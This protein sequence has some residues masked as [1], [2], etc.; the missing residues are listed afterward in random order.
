MKTIAIGDTHGQ[1]DWEKVLKQNPDFDKFIFIG[2]YFDSFNIPAIDQ[3]DNFLQILNFQKQNP[4]KVVL[5][6]GNHDFHYLPGIKDK[7]SGFQT[8]FYYQIQEMLNFAKPYL[9]MCFK[10]DNILFTHAGIT[11][12]WLNEQKQF[13]ESDDVEEIINQIYTSKPNNFQFTIGPNLSQYGDDKCQTPIW[14]RPKSLLRDKIDNFIQVV[15]HT[16]HDNLRIEDD[17]Y[18]IDTLQTSK[19]YLIIEDGNFKIGEIL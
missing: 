12:T 6:I 4:D 18:F 14:V 3:L 17:V 8:N 7:C 5:L 1:H 11:K 2:D 9:K 15:G 19:E 13:V 16:S 10:L